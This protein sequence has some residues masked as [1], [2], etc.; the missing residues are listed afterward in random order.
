LGGQGRGQ[1]DEARLRRAA[2]LVLEH[3][4]L[5]GPAPL[6]DFEALVSKRA[7]RWRWPAGAGL[8]LAAGA[9]LALFLV[10]RTPVSYVVNGPVAISGT[11]IE[12]DPSATTDA[13]VR[14]S[15]GTQVTLRPSAA[16]DVVER[17][18]R[19]ALLSLDRGVARFSVTHL[20][21]A[22][23]TVVAGPFGIEVTGTEFTVDWSP[24]AGKMVVDLAVGSVRVRGASVGG[25]VEL[26]AGERLVATVADHRVTLSPGGDA[27]PAATV[28]P[29]PAEAPAPEAQAAPAPPPAA[30]AAPTTAAGTVWAS[31]TPS[32]SRAP[33]TA[34]FDGTAE[35][36]PAARPSDLQRDVQRDIQ[37]DLAVWSPRV[38]P[39][40]TDEL[41]EPR[42]PTLPSPSSSLAPAARPS[43]LE[44]PRLDPS[45][46][47]PPVVKAVPQ[48]LTIGGGGAF[49]V[50][51][52]AQYAFESAVS[53]L[54]SP[55]EYT[56]A[57]ANPRVDRSHSWCGESSVRLEASFDESGRRN[58]FG[59]YARETGQL[60]IRLNQPVNLTGRTV[61]MHVFVEGPSDVR[62]SAELAAVHAGRWISSHPLEGLSPGRW[63][64]IT[65]RFDAVNVAGMPGSSNPRPYPV[66]GTAPASQVDR[67]ALAIHSTGDRRAWRGAVFV[68]DISWK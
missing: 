43:G 51:E 52:P 6:P 7:R 39:G 59:R 11:R 38:A 24:S 22:R 37:R 15:E 16:L 57:L 4:L 8:T 13:R 49:C 40:P 5:T 17:T 3:E 32:R 67:L 65:H 14:F 21:G 35:P 66:G 54:S 45:P 12:A 56:L 62:F 25:A 41:P 9:A 58:F 26:H 20:R 36:A 64:T 30:A 63:W 50:A 33:S 61:T 60:V 10:G 53:G 27:K 28:A 68:D 47:P 44:G 29:A 48:S 46:V 2:E 23:W 31:L 1:G 19:G 55:T 18:S 34:V 42:V